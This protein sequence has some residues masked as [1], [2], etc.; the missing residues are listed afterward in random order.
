MP[1]Q[2]VGNMV[3]PRINFFLF[4]TLLLIISMAFVSAGLFIYKN[5][6]MGS[7][8][9][10][11]KSLSV[12][13]DSFQ[14]ESISEL[15]IFN[16]R[17]SASNQILASHTVLSPVFGLLSEMTIPTIQFT[18][19]SLEPSVDG[20]N[21]TA[22]LS[23]L[24]RSYKS[25]AVQIDVFNGSKGKYFKN[26]VFSNLVLQNDKNSKG[27]VGFDLSFS[28][29]PALLSYDKSIITSNSKKQ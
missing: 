26:A 7:I 11:Q 19:M 4:I 16:K 22:R 8:K 12:A 10:L 14:P 18:R 1:T 21:F 6:L 17:M 25:I 13:K 29:D 15:Q 20:K 9:G 5:S 28:I 3:R 24:A 23:G 2:V 27:Y